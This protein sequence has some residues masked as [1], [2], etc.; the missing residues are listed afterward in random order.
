MRKMYSEDTLVKLVNENSTELYL[1]K[2]VI[3][4]KTDADNPITTIINMISCL[5]SK[6]NS[7]IDF[8]THQ[9]Y[10]LHGTVNGSA[11]PLISIKI[12]SRI[13]YYFDT[14]DGNI[15]SIQLGANSK[16]TFTD[17]VSKI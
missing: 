15:T 8:T 9:T 10:M 13:I 14:S 16:L 5:S 12:S 4:D 17:S 3:V 1:H 6:V 2:I 11:N 7:A